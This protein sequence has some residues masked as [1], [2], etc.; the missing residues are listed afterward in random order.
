[1]NHIQG[2]LGTSKFGSHYSYKYNGKELQ[3]TGMYDYG[4]RFY[5]PDIGRWGVA[6]PLAE[7]SRRFSPYNYGLNNPIMFIDPDGRKA[8]VNDYQAM[9]AEYTGF[10]ESQGN[11]VMGQMLGGGGR[12]T[13]SYYPGNLDGGGSGAFGALTANTPSS[14]NNLM[15]YFNSNGSTSNSIDYLFNNYKSGYITWWTGGAEGNANTAQEM[16]AHMLN[17]NGSD[18]PEIRQS[19]Y[20]FN[21]YKPDN[22]PEWYSTGGRGNWGLGVVGTAVEKISGEARVTSVG[23][24]I[25]LYRPNAN[26]NVFIKNAYTKTIGLKGVGEMVGKGSFWLGV[27]MDA[28]G[29]YNYY[30]NPESTNKVHPAKAG[31]NT[32][33]GAYG[34]WINPA[35]GILY[36]GVD[37]FYPGGWEGYG[38]DYQ[39]IQS[40][41]AAIMPGFI[42]APYGSQK[43]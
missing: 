3:E 32:A 14:V 7:I 36:F 10:I 43:F 40:D 9:Q 29:V 17:L 2:S 28:R 39:S 21:P 31:L 25:K 16:V 5:M 13:T 23:S 33:I 4:A 24:T 15:S 20:N 11:G 38:N 42:T 35:A 34:T 37:A 1:M 27:A 18:V 12:L 8:L 26:G 6:D 22:T 41:N 30:Y 19:Y